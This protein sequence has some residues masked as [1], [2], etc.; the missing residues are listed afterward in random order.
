[1]QQAFIEK[2]VAHHS[3]KTQERTFKNEMTQRGKEN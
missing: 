2:N 3:R 1:M